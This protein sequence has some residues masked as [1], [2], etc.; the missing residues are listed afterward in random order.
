MPVHERQPPLLEGHL[1]SHRWALA[2]VV[3]CSTLLIFFV[4]TL[5]QFDPVKYQLSPRC[6]LQETTGLFCSGCG[7]LRCVHHLANGRISTAF[8]HNPA[9]VLSLPLW[10]WII[11]AWGFEWWRTG[12]VPLLLTHRR[13][14]VLLIAITGLFILLG[15]LRNLPWE[16]FLQLAP[17]AV[18]LP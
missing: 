18:H 6:P 17:P 15:I 9:L 5:K 2:L 3:F 7:G 1:I 10:A 11:A 14:W 4:A 8:Q 16:P 12:R 13:S